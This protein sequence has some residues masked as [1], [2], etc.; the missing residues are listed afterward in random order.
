MLVEGSLGFGGG[1]RESVG[2]RG[3][4]DPGDRLT[5]RTHRTVGP[6]DASTAHR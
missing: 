6:A 4:M 1:V 5:I 3:S 2:P